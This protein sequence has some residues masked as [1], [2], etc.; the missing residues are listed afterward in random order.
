MAMSE[1]HAQHRLHELVDG[2]VRVPVTAVS[3]AD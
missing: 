1:I 2:D 3:L